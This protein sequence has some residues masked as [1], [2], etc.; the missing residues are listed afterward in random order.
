LR[1]QDKSLDPLQ[2]KQ[3]LWFI[4]HVSYRVVF[5]RGARTHI[6]KSR[7]LIADIAQPLHTAGIDLGGNTITV[8]FKGY[9]TSMHAVWD[10]AI[11]NSILGLT[12]NASITYENSFGFASKLA[13][14]INMGEYK[15]CTC[16]WIEHYNVH[17]WQ[18]IEDAT[19]QWADDT[20]N[21]VCMYVLKDGDAAYNNT[22]VGGAYAV[23]AYPI[24]EEALARAGV[25]L[26][27]W[28]NLIFAGETGF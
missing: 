21:W 11:P 25:R 17:S 24:V 12:P 19:L 23:G 5:Y 9:K 8:T 7:Q 27:A 13:A 18:E 3:A 14:A 6:F 1:L 4:V 22:E 10:T 28:L 20:N 16:S 26:S 2:R 15:E